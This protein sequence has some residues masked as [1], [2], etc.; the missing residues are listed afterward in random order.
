[1]SSQAPR[2]A[3]ARTHAPTLW[4]I[5][6]IKLGKG[7]FF[8][9]LALGVYGLSN[10]NLPHAFQQLLHIL[11]LDPERQFVADLAAK[12]EHI[13]PASVRWVA[14]GTF[15][16]SLFSLVEGTGLLLR[17]TW[18]CW[19]TIGESVFFIPIEIFE[20]LRKPSSA[21][22]LILAL[23]ILIVCYLLEN[24]RRLFH[25]HLH[26]AANRDAVKGA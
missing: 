6:L 10:E 9:L 17:I 7:L 23:N 21:M 13:T 15:V 19:M 3:P 20:L 4:A 12:I 26:R 2:S 5:I 1:M 8:L 25:K 18:A 14:A 11:N 24:R 16:Y 22:L